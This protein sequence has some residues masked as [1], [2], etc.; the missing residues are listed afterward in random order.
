MGKTATNL[1]LILGL[2]TVAFAGYYMYTQRDSTVLSFDSNAQTME[3]MLNNTRVFIERRQTLDKINLNL[4]F[5]DDPRLLSLRSF[6]T[7]VTERPVGRPNPFAETGII[8][9]DSI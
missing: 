4:Q 9:T 7:P 2:I 5:F 6:S 3:D 8:N 1:S